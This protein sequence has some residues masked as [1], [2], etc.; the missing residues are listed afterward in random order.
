M[1]FGCQWDSTT[2][3]Y[4]PQ[5]RGQRFP[6]WMYDLGNELA[7]TASD[8]THV[9]PPGSNFAPDVA[10]VNFYPV[11]FF[12][13][14]WLLVHYMLRTIGGNVASSKKIC[15][16]YLW[17][18]VIRSLPGGFICTYVNEDN[19]FNDS[20]V[21]VEKSVLSKRGN[22]LKYRAN[23]HCVS[24]LKMRS[25]GWW[26]WEVIRIWMITV[27]CL[28]YVCHFRKKRMVFHFSGLLNV[29]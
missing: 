29:G 18:G 6:A 19:Y 26:A 25:L 23:D 27:T 8:H 12:G 4:A 5:T 2:R 15:K 7:S 13:Q 22:V 10:L 3:R 20:S 24:R 16:F 17:I 28:W 14:L 21:S 11:S 9:Y 1:A